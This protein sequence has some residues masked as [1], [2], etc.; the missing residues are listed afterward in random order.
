MTGE[1]LHGA[2]WRTYWEALSVDMHLVADGR[3]DALHLGLS[4]GGGSIAHWTRAPKSLLRPSDDDGTFMD[5]NFTWYH[6]SSSPF[7]PWYEDGERTFVARGFLHE[8]DIPSEDEL[9]GETEVTEF[10][11][12][13]PDV[14]FELMARPLWPLHA[15]QVWEILTMRMDDWRQ[16]SYL[17]EFKKKQDL[18]PRLRPLF[19]APSGWSPAPDGSLAAAIFRSLAYGKGADRLDEKLIA[20]T[21]NLVRCFVDMKEE[22]SQDFGRALERSGYGVE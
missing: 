22:L 11:A 15:G 19:D 3:P 9:G 10:G 6:Q 21:N 18:R 1:A 20:A 5:R 16:S 17:S 2:V 8:R 13:N 4:F 12:E 14:F 7:V